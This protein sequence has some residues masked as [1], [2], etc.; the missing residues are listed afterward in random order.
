MCFKDMTQDQKNRCLLGISYL[1]L[2]LTPFTL[3]V[4]GITYA[5]TDTSTSSSGTTTQKVGKMP[6]LTT[7]QKAQLDAISER[8]ESE[9]ASLSEVFNRASNW[10]QA[11]F[12]YF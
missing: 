4:S 5:S 2:F 7:E 10:N 11:F 8:L 1:L 6:E 3:G 9:K 12:K